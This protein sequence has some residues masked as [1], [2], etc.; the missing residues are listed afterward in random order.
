MDTLIL[1]F[2]LPIKAI[3]VK[4]TYC[5]INHMKV[6]FTGS[7]RGREK[8]GK[9]YSKLEAVLKTN[10]LEYISPQSHKYSDIL[11][12]QAMKGLTE[13]EVHYLFI[14]RGIELSDATIIEASMDTFRLGH[15][16]TL[17]LI[18]NKPVLCL[19][20][21][22]DYS[23]AIKHP[24]FYSGQYDT[25]DEL[26]S[27]V[28]DFVNEVKSKLLSI[29]FNGMMSPKQKAFIE[30]LGKEEGKSISEVIRDLIDNKMIDSDK[31]EK[32][33]SWLSQKYL[34]TKKGK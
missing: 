26:E 25:L 34:K 28:I 4:I 13:E 11:E 31:F 18:H 8:Y 22:R 20:Q 33:F 15:E 9:A 5:Y 23:K 7:Q 3:C 2:S 27:I 12:K 24:S 32:D 10:D 30:W 21:H 14:S 16:A 19:S 1:V 29:R 6:F 17:S